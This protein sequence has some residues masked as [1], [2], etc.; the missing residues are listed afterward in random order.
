M[1]SMRLDELPP[2]SD[3]RLAEIAAM[4][5]E[6]IDTSD[7]PDMGDNDEFW[8]NATVGWP[9][10]RKVHLS[11]RLDSDVVDYFKRGG[12]GYQSRINAVLR[13]YV[14]AQLQAEAEERGR[15]QV[16]KERK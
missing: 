9:P 13:T 5:D 12:R 11:V 14:H 1:T 15:R 4:R 2:V 16:A 3:E 8:E 7:I 10:P 6:D